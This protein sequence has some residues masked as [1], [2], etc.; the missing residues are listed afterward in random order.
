M[1]SSYV[2]YAFT[3]AI[4][5]VATC[6]VPYVSRRYNCTHSQRLRV[7]LRTNMESEQRGGKLDRLHSFAT[8]STPY[9]RVNAV[10]S[11]VLQDASM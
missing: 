5:H 4:D 9:S 7:M 8:C 3:K 11:L 2:H 1:S 6:Y 10:L